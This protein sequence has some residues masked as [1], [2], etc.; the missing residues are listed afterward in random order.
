M[1]R[2]AP[3]SG[4]PEFSAGSILSDWFESLEE[5]SVKAVLV[6]GPDRRSPDN[7]REVVAAYPEAVLA[8]ATLL[9]R[10]P[11]YGAAWRENS[12]SLVAWKNL[13]VASSD[14]EFWVSEWLARGAKALVRV[15]LPLP[16]NRAFESYTFTGR[17]LVDRKEAAAIAWSAL[18]VWP[19]L[20]EKF[21]ADRFEISAREREILMLL[22]AGMTAK[23]VAV[24]VNCT[25][26]TVTFHLTNLKEK[27]G[28]ENKA[29][30]IQ[31]ACSLGVI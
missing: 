27:L 10:S 29:S 26:R 17:V 21:N 8:P 15:E 20:R 6:L 1:T 3:E 31:R 23:E 24:V 7:T 18:N 2:S 19:V 25:E 22:A 14:D 9:A 28:A 16:F 30:V 12:A 11:S 4:D 5:Y 13:S